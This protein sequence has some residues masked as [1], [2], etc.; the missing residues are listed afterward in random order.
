MLEIFVKEQ[1]FEKK[2]FDNKK[3][4]EFSSVMD[5]PM[6]LNVSKTFSHL[7]RLGTRNLIDVFS[8]VFTEKCLL[9]DKLTCVR[10]E[11]ISSALHQVR[12][13]FKKFISDLFLCCNKCQVNLFLFQRFVI[14]FISSRSPKVGI[15]SIIPK[16]CPSFVNHWQTLQQNYR[17]CYKQIRWPHTSNILDITFHSISA[18]YFWL[19]NFSKK[20]LKERNLLEIFVKE[21][22]FWKK[23]FD[24]RKW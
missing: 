18:A 3:L 13:I 23:S 10:M 6:F 20:L 15:C 5:R 21:Q 11:K 16:I 12:V 4:K 14:I 17:T 24:N 19:Q 7:V 9:F 1:F 22:C 8:K 2:C